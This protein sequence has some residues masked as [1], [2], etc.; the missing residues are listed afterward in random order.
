MCLRVTFLSTF[1]SAIET[2]RSTALIGTRSIGTANCTCGPIAAG[3]AARSTTIPVCAGESRITLLRGLDDDIA[4]ESSAL[5]D[6]GG[7]DNE[8]W[9]FEEEVDGRIEIGA[10]RWRNNAGG[11]R[12][13]VGVCAIDSGITVIVDSIGADFL[14]SGDT[15]ATGALK[16]ISTLDIPFALLAGF[17]R[18]VSAETESAAI[19]HRTRST[20]GAI[21]RADRTGL[22]AIGAGDACT[23]E[24]RVILARKTTS[25]GA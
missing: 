16:A 6:R 23:A 1:D 13:T 21:I 19:R 22:G 20:S 4:A 15:L 25:T 11:M 2:G 10:F 9:I 3:K 18:F 17:Y 8:T 5:A 14:D 12:K 7:E 24:S